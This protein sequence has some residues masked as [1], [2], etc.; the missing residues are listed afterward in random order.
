MRLIENLIL[1]NKIHETYES[2]TY[3]A[4]RKG[5]L[6]TLNIE[7]CI[8]YDNDVTFLDSL[9][10][11]S[12]IDSIFLSSYINFV[13]KKKYKRMTGTDI[14]KYFLNSNDSKKKVVLWGASEKVRKKIEKDFAL[15]NAQYGWSP[16][17]SCTSN[18]IILEKAKSLPKNSI[19]FTAFNL[20]EGVGLSKLILRNRN[21]LFFIQ[22]GGAF[23]TTAGR[24]KRAPKSFQQYGFEWLWKIVQ[25]PR[26]LKRLLFIIQYILLVEIKRF[27]KIKK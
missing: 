27:L 14:F 8:Q 5:I 12:V 26:R 18:Q 10:L 3:A 22:V 25:D 24:F 11:S 1:K 2:I 6:I 16:D 4:Q 21:D 23:D 15:P 17:L 7:W 20:N 19:I 13:Y 9:D